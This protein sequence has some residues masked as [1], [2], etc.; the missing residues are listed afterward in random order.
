MAINAQ[1]KYSAITGPLRKVVTYVVHL[2]KIRSVIVRE[3]LSCVQPPSFWFKLC[4]Q[5]GGRGRC[6]VWYRRHERRRCAVST[7]GAGVAGA[8]FLLTPAL[9]AVPLCLFRH[10][11][12]KLTRR[13]FDWLNHELGSTLRITEYQLIIYTIKT[14]VSAMTDYKPADRH[15]R[16][17]FCKHKQ[18]W[19]VPIHKH[20]NES[21]TQAIAA[22]A[23]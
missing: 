21:R 8:R 15:P 23:F 19:I 1:T 22:P 14:A 10:V 20:S 16:Q 9:W 11:L 17:P 7:G 6:A 2:L 5:C 3:A 4:R 18:N 13:V 12:E